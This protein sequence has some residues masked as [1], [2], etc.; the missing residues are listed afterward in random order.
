M[1][2]EVC[3]LTILPEN[4][5]IEVPKG[6]NLFSS[7][8][9]EGIQ[10]TASCGGQGT[11]G[12]C[13]VVIKSGEYNTGVTPFLSKQEMSEGYVLACLTLVEGDLTVSIPP[14][15]KLFGKQIISGGIERL[16]DD[17]WAIGSW[18][19]K[20]R[21]KSFYLRLTA[22]SLDDN[23]SDFDRICSA[24]S[25][26]GCDAYHIHCSL[27]L[28]KNLAKRVREG[29]WNVTVT[30]M[31]TCDGI[32]I[33]DVQPG[34]VKTRHYG[35][36]IDVG[37]TSIVCYLVDLLDGRIILSES[38][39]N[40]QISCGE[41]IISRIIYAKTPEGL[42]RL[43][44]LVVSVVNR[45]ILQLVKN[46][47]IPIESIYS[48]SVVGNTTMIHLL[49]GLNPK[50][51]RE[52]PYIPT[53][54]SIPH[55]LKASETGINVAMNA[56]MTGLPAISSYVGSDITAGILAT[57]M[58]K[59]SEVSVFMDIGTNG[60]IVVGNKD[61]MVA[62]SC[63][64]GPAFEGGEVKFGMRASTGAIDSARIDPLTFEPTYSTIH[65]QSPRGI[66]GS[67]ILDTLAEMFLTK[68]VD[69]RGKINKELSH[70]RIRE[71]DDG[72]EYV[73]VWAKETA[74]GKDICLTEVDI[75]N[76]IRAKGAAYAVMRVL[77]KETGLSV[78]K[79]DTFLI[80]GG[81]GHCLNIENAI[82]IGLLPDLP[83]DKFRYLGN[84]AIVGA[85]LALVSEDLNKEIYE[86][87]KG[88][89]YIELST[90][91]S[92][93]DEYVSA[94]FLPHTVQDLFPSV[95]HKLAVM[96]NG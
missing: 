28:L 57:G 60:E 82:T 33:I 59:L 51:I 22:P 26:K 81:F 54:N 37:T 87:A 62:A 63:S 92:F 84:S 24:L 6:S 78:D 31:P 70:P 14:G 27:P 85:Y 69:Q 90:S 86:T 49:L 35:V 15:S 80:A 75:D 72:W 18:N 20:H 36:A 2:R 77:L 23:R 94:L 74:I 19:I 7:L 79:V 71:G 89:A 41:D 4:K 34:E 12:T 13:K 50:Y 73:I 5:V 9:D 55:Y 38:D 56:Y 29:G 43:Q 1:I 67:G 39:Y 66:C 25:T 32:E 96:K 76:I 8:Q 16:I 17:R 42:N 83:L 3:R 47:Q 64:A 52:D 93:M 61:W 10:L 11:C 40:A 46:A 65:R 21:T 44:N 48:I 91:T 58:Y 30:I 88:I 68:I 45:I 95:I 53:I